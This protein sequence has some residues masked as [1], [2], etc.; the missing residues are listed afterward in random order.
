MLLSEDRRKY[1]ILVLF[2]FGGVL[3]L[4]ENIT[5]VKLTKCFLRLARYEMQIVLVKNYWL[6]ISVKDFESWTITMLL[7]R[8]G[9][10]DPWNNFF[11]T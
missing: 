2:C 10:S 1:A 7:A 5:T 8:E 11:S 6:K 9:F 4:F 3:Q